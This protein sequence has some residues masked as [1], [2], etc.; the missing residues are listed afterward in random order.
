MADCP[1]Y[2]EDCKKEQHEECKDTVVKYAK[3]IFCKDARCLWNFELE[4]GKVIKHHRDYVPLGDIDSYKGICSR[5]E[6]GMSHEAFNEGEGT[7][8]SVH[9]EIA[10]C[11]FRSDVSRDTHMDFSKFVNPTGG[12]HIADPIESFPAASELSDPLAS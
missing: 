9:R 5:P 12:S 6:I 4:Q 8:H 2:G 11:D 7:S 3:V 1:L 10:T